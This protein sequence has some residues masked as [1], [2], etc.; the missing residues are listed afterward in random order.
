MAEPPFGLLPNNMGSKP[1]LPAPANGVDT[2]GAQLGTHHAALSSNEAAIAYTKKEK[3]KQVIPALGQVLDH[4]PYSD[5]KLKE[6]LRSTEGD[7][8]IKKAHALKQI[9]AELARRD[10]GGTL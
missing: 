9:Q 1:G 7:K 10:A 5:G 3:A 8:N 2:A 6:N 4:K